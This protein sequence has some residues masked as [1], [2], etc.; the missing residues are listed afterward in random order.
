M[1]STYYYTTYADENG[2][3]AFTN[4]R[5][6]R[7]YGLQAWSSGGALADV[8][9]TFLQNDVRVAA[10]ATTDFS[11]SSSLA[12]WAVSDSD[13]NETR[14][15]Q[16]GDF[17]RA[18]YGFRHGGAP[19]AHAAADDC[20]AS[21]TY[22]VGSSNTTDWCF[23]QTKVG[24]WTIAFEVPS[25]A[26]EEL[27][28]REAREE[29]TLIVSLA[30]YSTGTD[31]RIYANGDTLVGN[32]TSGSELLAN[33]PSLYRSAT[34]AGEWRYL[35]FVFDAGVLQSG[36]NNI[37]FAVTNSTKWRGIMWDSI[38]LEW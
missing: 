14:L 35:E 22:T 6:G 16:V 38:I 30:G 12:S 19:Y 9:T 8:T 32:L 24:N 27:E 31:A 29:A 15:F 21:L 2:T 13:G 18:S 34:A 28:E 5:A 3:F 23:A 17:D 36:W 26:G 37:T 1:G 33:D 10:G 25:A 7:S 20:P 4:V 11:G